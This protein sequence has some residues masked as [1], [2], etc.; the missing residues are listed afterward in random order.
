MTVCRKQDG[1]RPAAAGDIV[2][3][4]RGSEQQRTRLSSNTRSSPLSRGLHLVSSPDPTDGDTHISA[5]G[6]VA[7]PTV[8]R[9]TTP[10]RT[11]NQ[12]MGAHRETKAMDAPMQLKSR[13]SLH[14]RLEES[15]VQADTSRELDSILIVDVKY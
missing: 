14:Q 15:E 11:T 12:P 9:G 6:R 4:F 13:K 5:Q 7:Q 3:G 10:F 2:R 8:R 1:Q